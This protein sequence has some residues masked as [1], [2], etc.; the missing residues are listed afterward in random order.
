MN[1]LAKSDPEILDTVSSDQRTKLSILKDEAIK[2]ALAN[3][4]FGSI[5]GYSIYGI[6]RSELNY[7]MF[8][9]W[10]IP[11]EYRKALDKYYILK[12]KPEH[13]FRKLTNGIVEH[14]G[15]FYYAL[16]HE[17]VRSDIEKLSSVQIS[18]RVAQPE[19][20]LNPILL[21]SSQSSQSSES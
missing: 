13:L 18:F 17:C 8:H 6:L 14:Q 19:Y 1:I 5:A 4:Q 15:Q 10:S 11:Q 7:Q 20:R 2:V 9:T 3:S 21:I 12:W 16:Y